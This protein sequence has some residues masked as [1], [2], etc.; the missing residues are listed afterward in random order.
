MDSGNALSLWFVLLSSRY[1]VTFH[2]TSYL[3]SNTLP[4]TQETQLG[5]GQIACLRINTLVNS[6]PL[7]I[8]SSILTIKLMVLNIGFIAFAIL[9]SNR[10]QAKSV[11]EL[12][13]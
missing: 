7:T 4:D 5:N 11:A 9:L 13:S 1:R 6:T 3:L 2:V 10:K 12:L 8:Q